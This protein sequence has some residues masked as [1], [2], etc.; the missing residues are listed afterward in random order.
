MMMVLGFVPLATISGTL[1]NLQFGSLDFATAA[2]VTPFALLGVALGTRA[3]HAVSTAVL[4][5]MA[6]GLCIAVGMFML[7]RSL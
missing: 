4:R 5:R 2:W 1:G 6:G 7:W 3:A